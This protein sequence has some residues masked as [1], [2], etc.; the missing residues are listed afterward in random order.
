MQTTEN[1]LTSELP[2]HSFTTTLTLMHELH[3]PLRANPLPSRFGGKGGILTSNRYRFRLA[4]SYE[5]PLPQ[6][7]LPLREGQAGG[8][9]QAAEAKSVPIA[10][11][12]ASCSPE[13]FCVNDI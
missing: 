12:Y 9:R 8:G 6:P 4:A 13:A 11:Q 2:I 7:G 5:A 1:E 10:R 3:P